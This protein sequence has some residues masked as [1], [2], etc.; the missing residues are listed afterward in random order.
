MK[1]LI[2]L[3]FLPL[4]LSL[5]AQDTKRMRQSLEKLC[6]KEFLG[7]GYVKEGDQKAANWIAKQFKNFGLSAFETDYIQKFTLP[8]VAFPET[9]RLAFDGNAL[10]AGLDFFPDPASSSGTDELKILMLDEAFLSSEKVRKKWLKKDLSNVALCYNASTR[11]GLLQLPREFVLKIL[12]VPL[13]IILEESLTFSIANEQAWMPTIHVKKDAFPQKLPRKVSFSITSKQHEAYTSQNVVGYVKGTK[14]PE[15]FIVFSAH[16][17]H[18]GGL[19]DEVYYAGAN[20]NASGVA[21]MLELAAHYVEN[22]P[23]TSVAF[24][25]FGA[26]EAGIFGSRYYVDNPLFPLSQIEFLLNLDLIGTGETGATLVNGKVHQE[27]FTELKELN[28]AGEYLP[29][30]KARGEAA[31]SDHYFFHL[32]GVPS[33]F[34]YLTTDDLSGIAYHH[35]GDKPETLSLAGIEG[36]FNLLTTFTETFD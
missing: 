14:S 3:L 10:K 23:E 29:N 8:V 9:P 18:L 32:K 17:D 27:A 4:S 12:R 36:L 16:Y 11:Q 20:D 25:A 21:F 24:I 5:Q 34:I 1:K 2:L 7:R 15:K 30:L 22:P 26:E 33:F 28:E 6:A 31:N 13:T 35:P 19:G